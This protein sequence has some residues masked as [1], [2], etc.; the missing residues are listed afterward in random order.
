MAELEATVGFLNQRFRSKTMVLHGA[1][2]SQPSAGHGQL[3]WN[4]FV[5]CRLN[6][7]ASGRGPSVVSRSVTAVTHIGRPGGRCWWGMQAVR[8]STRPMHCPRSSGAKASTLL[9]SSPPC[10]Q[11][12]QAQQATE[13]DCTALASIGYRPWC[14]HKLMA[15]NHPPLVWYQLA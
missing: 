7:G 13:S 4:A 2:T 12:A 15:S 6:E 8:L 3:T 14:I 11:T 10:G 5:K 9:M 1:Q